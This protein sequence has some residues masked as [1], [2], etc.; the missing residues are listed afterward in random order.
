MCSREGPDALPSGDGVKPL[1][2]SAYPN[3][4]AARSGETLKVQ[5]HLADA[6]DVRAEVYTT[7]G[8]RVR[9]FR[10]IATAGPG[11]I[12]VWDGSTQDGSA[13]PPGVYFVRVEGR[14]R[15]GIRHR[16]VL[17]VLVTP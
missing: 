7:N 1:S 6:V 2:V 3:P 12:A 11:P 16:G 9:R 13:A 4:Y 10:P 17:R 5:Y 14:D 15:N 8:R